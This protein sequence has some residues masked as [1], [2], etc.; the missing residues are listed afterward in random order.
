MTDLD[1]SSLPMREQVRHHLQ[2]AINTGFRGQAISQIKA[3]VELLDYDDKA[4]NDIHCRHLRY[5]SKPLLDPTHK[6]LRLEAKLNKKVW[7]YRLEVQEDGKS[8]MKKIKL[9]EYPKMT[10]SEAREVFKNAKI[11]R[12]TDGDGELINPTEKQNDNITFE[13]LAS[14]YMKHM[15]SSWELST[16]KTHQE[17]LNSNVLHVIGK[18]K[19]SEIKDEHIFKMCSDIWN[20]EHTLP[21]LKKDAKPAPRAAEKALA[22]VRAI[23][24]TA[25]GVKPRKKTKNVVRLIRPWISG[26]KNPALS[27]ELPNR[28]SEST[29]LNEKDLPNFIKLLPSSDM[30]QINKDVLMVQLL[31]SSRISE[32]TELKI[33][34]LDLESGLW[35]L[36]SER[37]KNDKEHRVMLSSQVIAILKRYI[38]NRT[39]AKDYVFNVKGA[40]KKDKRDEIGRSLAAN[41]HYLESPLNLTTHSLRHTVLSH[42]A[43][44]GY[45]KDV[46][47]FVSNHKAESKSDMDARYNKFEN[48]DEAREA[49]Q[50]FADKCE[51]YSAE[52]LAASE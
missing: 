12:E 9:G 47:D 34:E 30:P 33:G 27:V 2:A 14:K 23:Y 49:L 8:R 35:T 45:G 41:R 44:L 42:I 6:G 10:L 48:E 13:D 24:N 38:G 31:T 46:R 32:V 28:E 22:L 50:E 18:L 5:G 16:A 4:L 26:I 19:V 20:G 37:A 40:T 1:V 15:R 3:A 25:L 21:R 29:W 7:Y 43:M 52:W 11:I 17:T 51:S 39:K 36:P